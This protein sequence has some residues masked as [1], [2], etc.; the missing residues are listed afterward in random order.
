MRHGLQL[1]VTG[2]LAAAVVLTA[3]ARAEEARELT[4][5]ASAQNSTRAA[6]VGPVQLDE[7]GGVVIR[8]AEQ[9]VALSSKAQAAKD[10]AVQKEIT[11]ELAKLLQMDAI[12]WSSQMAVAVRGE[13]GTKADKIRFDSLKVDNNV[14]TVAWK[15]IPRPPHAGPGTPIALILVER[16]DGEVKFVLSG[17]K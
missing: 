7:L 4:I 16:F 9:L 11:A 14:L 1:T 5:L 12:D 8:S 15:V 13:P 2:L 3:T 17:Q 10:G 6:N